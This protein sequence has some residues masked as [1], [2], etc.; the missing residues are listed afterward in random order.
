MNGELIPWARATVHVSAH[1]LHYGSGVFEGMRCYETPAGP[2]IFRL[3]AHFKRFYASATA[4]GIEIPYTKDQLRKAVCRLVERNGFRS[5][6]V[7]PIC[8]YGSDTLAVQ[9]LDCPVQVAIFAWP[10][11]PLL[12][13]RKQIEGARVTISSWVKFHSSM[14]PTT[15]KACGQYLNSMLALKEAV[16]RG[17]DEALL[18]DVHGN[19]AEGAGENIFLVKDGRLLTNDEQS[20]ILLGITR[21]SVI[22][23]AGE[24]GYTVDVGLL[25]LDDLWS[26][27][28]AFFTG[29]AV[30][31][32]P[33][34]EVDGT[35]IGNGRKGLVTAEIQ[36]AF[37]DVTSGKTAGKHSE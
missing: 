33:I 14:M 17:F 16:S 37:F 21:N 18:L 19:I 29:T 2:A 12:G 20:S 11:A 8:Y 5:C 6:Y 25:R 23:I 1:T 36:R 4:Y 7:R 3:R 28:E 30:E 15:A 35:I 22:Q 9:P 13:A 31:I 10:W 34:C 26:A 24:L 32:T 27:D